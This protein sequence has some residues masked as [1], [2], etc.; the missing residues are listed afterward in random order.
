MAVPVFQ[1]G[2]GW[3]Q[4]RGVA[5]KLQGEQ[6]TAYHQR[7]ER[8]PRTENEGGDGGIAE[9]RLAGNRYSPLKHDC[10][11]GSGDRSGEDRD[12]EMDEEERL[13]SALECLEHGTIRDGIHRLTAFTAER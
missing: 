6:Q 2:A 10:R 9:R 11:D 4:Q 5:E 3:N 8:P 12:R 13:P 1:E 7:R